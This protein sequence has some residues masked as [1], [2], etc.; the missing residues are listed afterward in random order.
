MVVVVTAPR[1]RRRGQGQQ[2]TTMP[3]DTPSVPSPVQTLSD[4][5][6][7]TSRAHLTAFGLNFGKLFKHK[8]KPADLAPDLGYERLRKGVAVSGT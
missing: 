4:R 6:G 1:A 3:V 5:P 7:A 8:L 2:R